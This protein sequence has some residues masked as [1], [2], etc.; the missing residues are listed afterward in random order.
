MP[1]VEC[2]QTIW[3]RKWCDD[4]HSRAY[5]MTL[6]IIIVAIIVITCLC[7]RPVWACVYSYAMQAT[8]IWRVNANIDL[9]IFYVN[10]NVSI[11]SDFYCLSVFARFNSMFIIIVIVVAMLCTT[12]ASTM[13]ADN[14]IDDVVRD[15]SQN[16]HIV[17]SF[18]WI[19]VQSIQCSMWCDLC[20][21]CVDV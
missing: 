11:C 7:L 19:K 8:V 12:N 13:T 17:L 14:G 10:V 2:G 6:H 9:H 21:K 15:S 3:A 20:V 16:Y 5:F 18:N 4:M 1:A